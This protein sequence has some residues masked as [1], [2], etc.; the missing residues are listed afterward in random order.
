MVAACPHVDMQP[1]ANDAEL[2]ERHLVAEAEVT[3]H[4]LG[5][6]Q[7]R[8]RVNSDPVETICPQGVA[9]KSRVIGVRSLNS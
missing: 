7:L 1:G 8:R 9:V 5:P 3:L 2:T 4:H 6:G